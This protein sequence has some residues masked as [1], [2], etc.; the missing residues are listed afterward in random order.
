M[1]DHLS[2]RASVHDLSARPAIAKVNSPG[3]QLKSLTARNGMP[4][5]KPRSSELKTPGLKPT[6]SEMRRTDRVGAQELKRRT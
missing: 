1:L 6:M 2:L 5:L 3:P 4:E